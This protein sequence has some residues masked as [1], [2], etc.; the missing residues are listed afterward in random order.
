MTDNIWELYDTINSSFKEENIIDS[1]PDKDKCL[2]CDESDFLINDG[3]MIVYV[4][5]V[6][7]KIIELLIIILNGD[8][9][10]V[11]IIKETVILIDVVCLL[12]K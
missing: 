5:I 3:E 4:Q 7:L 10:V 8:Y 6:E 1:K 11:M 9:M 12:I 2:S